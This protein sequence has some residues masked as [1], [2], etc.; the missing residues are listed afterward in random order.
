MRKKLFNKGQVFGK[1]TLDIYLGGGGNGEVWKCSSKEGIVGAMKLLK[2][3]NPKS[4]ARFLDETT[5]I[6]KKLRYCRDC[7]ND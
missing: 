5:I 3:V 1:W 6:E 2:S 7:S 4:Y